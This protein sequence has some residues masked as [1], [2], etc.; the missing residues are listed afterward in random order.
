MGVNVPAG[1]FENAYMARSIQPFNATLNIDD[2]TFAHID[3]LIGSD[4]NI[5][6]SIEA[7]LYNGG[8]GTLSY[9]TTLWTD[10][11]GAISPGSSSTTT[12]ASITPISLTFNAGDALVLALRA[13][14]SAAE[15]GGSHSD[16]DILLGSVASNIALGFEFRQA[17]SPARCLKHY[18]LFKRLF[19]KLTG[20]ESVNP[21]SDLLTTDVYP[22]P[23]VFNLNPFFTF[24]TSGDALRQLYTSADGSIVN[25]AIKINFKDFAKHCFN[26]NAAGIGIEL[27]GDGNEGLRMESLGYFFRRDIIIADLGKQIT[28]W[29]MYPYNDYKANNLKEGYTDQS[30]DEVNGRFEWNSETTYKTP[31]KSLN[32]DIDGLSS[33]RVDCY[34]IEYTRANLAS[35]QTTDAGSDNDT[36][37]IQSNGNLLD[38]EELS[39]LPYAV[40]KAQ[41]VTAGLPASVWP[42]VYN[43][44]FSVG[45]NMGRMTVWLK[46]V[47]FNLVTRVLEFTSGKKNTA[48]VSSMY[49]GPT[50]TENANIDLIPIGDASD[51][52]FKPWV[53]EFD[54]KVPIDLPERMASANKYGLWRFTYKGVVLEG[55]TLEAGIKDGTNDVFTFKLLCGPDTVVPD[56]L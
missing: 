35:K 14:T 29:S 19:W 33:I 34:G 44:A 36:F 15:T 17:D 52:Y 22:G 21:V 38:I 11:F 9:H 39:T 18:D 47:Y 45:R 46:S 1:I 56:N 49:T 53:F 3:N 7:Y 16:L 40:D 2:I 50:V 54:A 27:D 51:I 24:F 6:L 25:P 12:T 13:T 23:E 41:T 5:T 31:V 48:I 8:F 26:V 30:Y 55:F 10:P 32:K 28:N 4:Q 43:M 37:A 42:T 20:S